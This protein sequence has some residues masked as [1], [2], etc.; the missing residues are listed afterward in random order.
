MTLRLEIQEP[1][2]E[3]TEKDLLSVY[4]LFPRKGP[5]KQDGLKALRKT[6]KTRTDLEDCLRAVGVFAKEHAGKAKEYIRHFDRWARSWRDWLDLTDASGLRHGA[7][8]VEATVVRAV[9][10]VKYTPPQPVEPLTPEEVR[11]FAE[12]QLKNLKG[13]G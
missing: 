8:H 9:L 11:A 3:V 12:E 7:V 6:V 5:G 4:A 10:S 1:A 2:P 13:G